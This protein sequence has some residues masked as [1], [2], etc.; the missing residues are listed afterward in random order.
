MNVVLITLL[1][2]AIGGLIVALVAQGARAS[3]DDDGLDSSD[4]TPVEKSEGDTAGTDRGDAIWCGTETGVGE[5]V[6]GEA[7][8]V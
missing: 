6:E 5:L 8:F 3:R 2:V 7:R 4:V 1:L